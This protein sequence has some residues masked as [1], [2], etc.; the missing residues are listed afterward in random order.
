[1]G[2]GARCPRHPARAATGVCQRC[3][4]FLCGGCA[5]RLDTRLYCE[6]CA[7]RLATGHSPRS[8]HALVLGVLSVHGLFFLAPVAAVLGALELGAIRQG[9]APLGGTWLARAGLVLGLCG[10]A[11]PVSLLFVLYATS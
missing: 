2:A 3:G 10:V 9:E 4:D 11:M 5:R 1:L 8:T 7:A 6:G